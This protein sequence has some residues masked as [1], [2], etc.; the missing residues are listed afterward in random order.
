MLARK[1]FTIAIALIS[2]ASAQEKTLEV[3]VSP[4]VSSSEKQIVEGI[5]LVD[6][7]TPMNEIKQ[8]HGVSVFLTGD[9]YTDL[10]DRLQQLLN[11]PLENS[12][13]KRAKCEISNYFRKT[14]QQYVYVMVPAQE[15]LDGIVVFQIIEGRIGTIKFTGQSL[16]L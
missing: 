15:V 16:F 10:K 8:D 4:K 11:C 14:K 2:F 12:F 3:A 9:D 1:L 13:I 6:G 7:G 5:I